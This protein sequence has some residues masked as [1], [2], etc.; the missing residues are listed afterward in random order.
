MISVVL[1]L[2]TACGEIRSDRLSRRIE[3]GLGV[4]LAVPAVPQDRSDGRIGLAAIT[5]NLQYTIAGLGLRMYLFTHTLDS[6]VHE[7]YLKIASAAM[8]GIR[9]ADRVDRYADNAV[10]RIA[11]TQCGHQCW[12]SKGL[13]RRRTQR[14]VLVEKRYCQHDDMVFTVHAFMC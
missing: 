1:I 14:S 11:I 3:E 13:N 6:R 10:V 2:N 4:V 8:I 9:D 5:N 12:S 7:V